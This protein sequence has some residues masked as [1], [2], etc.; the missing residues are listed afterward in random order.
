MSG[1]IRDE[2][3]DELYAHSE[4][5]DASEASDSAVEEHNAALSPVDGY[6]GQTSSQIAGQMPTA[7]NVPRVPNVMVEDPTLRQ[8]AAESKSREAAEEALNRGA[9][10]ESTPPESNPPESNPP[11]LQQ[12]RNTAP[13]LTSSTE[14]VD[15]NTPD[16]RLAAVQVTPD[17]AQ[18]S[19]S[20]RHN[21]RR[22]SMHRTRFTHPVE[23]DLDL[24]APP[25]YTPRTSTSYGT[26][27]TTP[28]NQPQFRDMSGSGERQPLMPAT[29]ESMALPFAES[30]VQNLSSRRR[31]WITGS[32]RHR[33]RAILNIAA[34]LTFIIITIAIIA[35]L[36]RPKHQKHDF[37]EEPVKPP[38]S[39]DKGSMRWRPPKRCLD[40]SDDHL[41]VGQ[42]YYF[43]ED[44]NLTVLQ[45]YDDA[46]VSG[47]RPVHVFGD[48]ILRP[49]VGTFATGYIAVESISNN[50]R[51]GFTFSMDRETGALKVLAPQ[52]IEWQGEL[53]PCM[54]LRITLFIPPEARLR[55]L[56]IQ[57]QQLDI[58]VENGL[59]LG[60]TEAA[61]FLTFS[62]DMRFPERLA[63]HRLA[64]YRLETPS[65]TVQ[66]ISGQL[67]GWYP[68]YENLDIEASYGNIMAT[69]SRKLLKNGQPRPSKLLAATNLGNIDIRELF[70]P[71]DKD[72]ISRDHQVRIESDSGCIYAEILHSSSSIIQSISGNLNLSIT[73][74]SDS[75]CLKWGHQ[76]CSI[77][78]QTSSGTTHIVVNQPSFHQSNVSSDKGWKARDDEDLEGHDRKG[79][80][81][82]MS[83]LHSSHSSQSGDIVASYPSLWEGNVI[84]STLY[85]DLDYS[86]EGLVMKHRDAINKRMSGRKGSGNSE[87]IVYTKSGHQKVAIR[88]EGDD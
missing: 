16:L 17:L 8:D 88:N 56:D 45:L 76:F 60:V 29:P 47:G 24:D 73:P 57:A 40:S 14:N 61:K 43:N 80:P 78:T 12:P 58:A 2:V 52:E 13:I 46:V 85:G 39:P 26:M 38:K 49:A 55:A 37:V 68:L 79:T 75:D 50:E 21:G 69:T 86:G 84:V 22:Q 42:S 44:R 28:S 63:N 35:Y 15:E 53:D 65:L 4:G 83:A 34:V 48:M 66:T 54:Q 25:A 64:P 5:G 19:S 32:L 87:M 36:L 11:E 67:S 77:A 41:S 3:D 59:V 23:N 81:H 30:D 10:S 51:I 18:P 6:Y 82:T 31:N 70:Q 1:G 62:G 72:I 7:A 33:K 71:Q 74:A 9:N 20:P 27:S